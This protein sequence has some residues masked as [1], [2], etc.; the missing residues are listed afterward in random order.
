LKSGLLFLLVEWSRLSYCGDG[1]GLGEFGDD[2]ELLHHAESIP[3]DIA[4]DHFAVGK[5]GN[6]DTGDGELLAGRS[7]SVEFALMGAVARPASGDGFA[8]GNQILDGEADV[9]EGIAIESHTLLL[10]VW[11]A[12]KIRRGR[13]VMIV[14]LC[15]ELIG[16]LLMTLVPNFIE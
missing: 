9:G 5:A 13:V 2:A 11:T 4:F 14:V 1:F 10:T 7:D 12:P 15:E 6:A 16:Y 3:V 8:F